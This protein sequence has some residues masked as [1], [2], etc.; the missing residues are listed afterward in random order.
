METVL[1][2]I[3][4]LLIRALAYIPLGASSL[5]FIIASVSVSTSLVG[6]IKNGAWVFPKLHQ[7]MGMD[8]L[9]LLMDERL[10]GIRRHLIEGAAKLASMPTV[11]VLG[12]GGTFCLITGFCLL[13]FA[14]AIKNA[15]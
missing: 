13:Q 1:R 6:W 5:S 7:S 12:M 15:K 3:V 4:E 14:Q 11:L 2:K 10:I 8:F 9:H